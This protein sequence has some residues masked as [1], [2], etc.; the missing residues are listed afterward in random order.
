MARP[1]HLRLT[2]PLALALA[3]LAGLAAADGDWQTG[4][5]F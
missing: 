3:L 5:E 1:C 2:A 4:R